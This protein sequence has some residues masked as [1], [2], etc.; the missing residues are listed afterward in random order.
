MSEPRFFSALS[1]LG[2]SFVPVACDSE[3]DDC[4]ATRS[5]SPAGKGGG[6]AVAGSSSGGASGKGSAG[7]A[8]SSAG[9]IATGG[10]AGGGGE[11]GD[12]GDSGEPNT[13]AEGGQG[14]HAL[15]GEAGMENGTAGDAGA[16]MGGGAGSGEPPE[17]GSDE[18]CDDQRFCNGQE[19]C[20][21]GRCRGAAAAFHCEN[22]DASQCGVS[23]REGDG[24]ADC[25]V[26]ALDGDE[27][28]FSSVLCEAAPGDDCDDGNAE[29]HPAAREACD[30]I[31]NDCDDRVDLDD[32]LTLSGSTKTAAAI[33]RIDVA[34]LPAASATSGDAQ[35]RLVFARTSSAGIFS[36][37]LDGAGAIDEAIEPLAVPSRSDYSDFRVVGGATRF[38]VSFSAPGYGSGDNDGTTTRLLQV[39]RD[40]T[41]SLEQTLGIGR[42][43]D[44][45]RRRSDWVVSRVVSDEIEVA[46]YLENGGSEDGPTLSV[47]GD[48]DQSPAWVR[49]AARGEDTAVIWQT[50][51]NF[52][53]WARLSSTLV[54]TNGAS[55]G[56]TG[57]YPEIAAAGDG[58]AMAWSTGSGIGFT[59]YTARGAGI[60]ESGPID[61]GLSAPQDLRRVALADTAFGTLVLVTSEEGKVTL[62]RFGEECEITATLP[63]APTTAASSPAIAVGSETV[64]LAWVDRTGAIAHT[65]RV[66]ERLCE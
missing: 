15:G 57:Y 38:G 35:F 26:E 5:C 17:C 2:L 63:I 40:G 61:L 39:D 49:I 22:P 30:G 29:I 12:P 7:A 66:G 34:W 55:I 65:R 58:Y 11:A 36:A 8:G 45:A 53:R 13:A 60:C 44:I 4:S 46:R 64:A 18:D 33:D 28:G 10:N 24:R 42:L 21:D 54:A 27:D 6:R 1:L 62:V 19:R 37:L 52:L 59:R 3:F 31:D 25:V 20:E 14:A 43:S 47:D 23:C 50:S 16:G 32:G 48:T 41:P 56:A 51:S 9:S